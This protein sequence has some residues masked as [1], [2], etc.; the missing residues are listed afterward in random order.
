MGLG[1]PDAN[2]QAM[3][4]VVFCTQK[5]DEEGV[6]MDIVPVFISALDFD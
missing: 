1:S 6:V 4:L 2:D 3:V 5:E